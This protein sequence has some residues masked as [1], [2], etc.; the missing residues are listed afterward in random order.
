MQ[1]VQPEENTATAVGFPNE[2]IIY[3]ELYCD[4]KRFERSLQG[5]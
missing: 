1:K 4:N 3:S 5:L 2:V